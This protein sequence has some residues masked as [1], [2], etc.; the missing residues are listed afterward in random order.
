MNGFIEGLYTQLLLIHYCQL[1]LITKHITPY[2]TYLN[3]SNILT[4]KV[5]QLNVC[6]EDKKVVHF[7]A[8]KCART[9]SELHVT[10]CYYYLVNFNVLSHVM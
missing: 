9:Y 3:V 2:N 7:V 10:P 1:C 4:V 5:R 8:S 6:G